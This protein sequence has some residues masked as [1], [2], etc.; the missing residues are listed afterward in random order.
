MEKNY[1]VHL[2]LRMDMDVKEDN[3]DVAYNKA[4]DFVVDHLNEIFDNMSFSVVDG[5]VT[6]ESGLR[7]D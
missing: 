6:D 3:P 7:V 5:S 2:I 1:T 4:Y